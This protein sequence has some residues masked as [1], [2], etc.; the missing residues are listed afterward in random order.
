MSKLSEDPRIDPRLK[1][2]FGKMPAVHG[3]DLSSREEVLELSRTDKAVAAREAL[4]AFAERAD[5]EE[6]APSHG[7]TVTTETFVSE[8][9]GNSIKVQLVRPD[10]DGDR[11]PCVYYIHGGGMAMMSCFDG[12]Y[13]AWGRMIAHWVSP[14]PWSISATRWCRPLL[15]RSRRIRLV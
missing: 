7:L 8:P 12:N 3:P 1:A 6:I 13:R 2:L 11:A 4:T 15:P 10:S 9:D 5:T 14:S